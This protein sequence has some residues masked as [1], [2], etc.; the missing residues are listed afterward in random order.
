MGAEAYGL[1]GI[2]A[3]LQALFSV[4]DVGL[5]Q[6][7]SR[8]SARHRGGAT[9]DIDY[10]RL[11]RS[12]EGIFLGVSILIIFIFIYF[13]ESI[14]KNWLKAEIIPIAEIK[15][16]LQ[17]MIVIVALRWSSGLYRGIISGNE[18]FVLLSVFNIGIATFRF[19]A[20]IPLLIYYNSEPTAFFTYQ[21]IISLFELA[22]LIIMTYKELPK[23]NEEIHIKWTWAPI[24]SILKFSLGLAFSGIVWI[25]ITQSDKLILSK[26]L[27]LKDYGVYSLA[28][29]AAAGLII[30]GAPIISA[31]LPRL[32]KMSAENNSTGFIKL[33]RGTTQIV[34]AITIPTT[35]ILVLFSENVLWAW[36]G[37]IEIAKSA[38]SI[39]VLYLIGNCILSMGS[40]PYYIQYAKGDLSLHIRGNLLFLLSFVPLLILFSYNYGAIGAGWSWLLFNLIYFIVWTPIVHNKFIKGMHI[41][42]LTFDIGPI[43]ASSIFFMLFLS[44][45]NFN[46]SSRIYVILQISILIFASI[47]L[48]GLS[49][50]FIRSKIFEL[51]NRLRK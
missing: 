42:W 9:T 31:I 29:T 27:N 36:T 41:K 46:I 17:L 12:L 26:L 43:L 38:N 22:G 34:A 25:L 19:I 11:V 4:L 13:S 20:V 15:Q 7:V 6:T 33:Y 14:S 1:V 47:S 37:N 35:L 24:N 21:I 44:R 16:S 8:E 48:A 18:R 30:I 50:K 49:T 40:F 3:M 45:F 51:Y 23:Q 10:L 5:T 2:F 32:S 28:V 39:F